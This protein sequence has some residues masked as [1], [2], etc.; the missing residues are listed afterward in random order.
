MSRISPPDRPQDVFTPSSLPA[1]VASDKNCQAEFERALGS[2]PDVIERRLIDAS[3]KFGNRAPDKTLEDNCSPQDEDARTAEPA[4]T[5]GRETIPDLPPKPDTPGGQA[6]NEESGEHREP[7]QACMLQSP[8]AIATPF[9]TVTT[10]PSHT[11][12]TPPSS[13]T[14]T[15]P[16][17]TETTRPSPTA[18]TTAPV[19]ATDRPVTATNQRDNTTAPLKSPEQNLSIAPNAPATRAPVQTP[20]D[21]QNPSGEQ[22]EQAHV[23]VADEDP[24]LAS[25]THQ[26]PGDKLLAR[27]LKTTE[28]PSFSR[29]L[30]KLAQTLQVHIQ[31][32]ESR[33]GSSTRL[34]VNLAQL[35]QVDVQLNHSR[36]EL[37]VE[38]Q[39]SP[40]SL[41][42][43]QLAR[44]DLME[45]LQRLHPGQPIQL[46]FAQQ[47]H[48]GDQGSRQR[49]HVYDEWEQDS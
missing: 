28:Q 14:A 44:G 34:Q 6:T 23:D 5:K 47:Q 15:T 2:R 36:G 41:L 10:K 26:T 13:T 3:R 20:A 7:D 49:R 39:A 33:N 24:K 30:D 1:L 29:D 8:I 4:N 42:Q 38:I 18:A 48:G 16:S 27:L 22:D 17:S 46:T 35:G 43:L 40:G 37:H 31:A 21:Q 32:G 9:S 11:T 12:T 19:P 25:G 45:R